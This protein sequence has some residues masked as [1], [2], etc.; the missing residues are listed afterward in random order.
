MRLSAVELSALL[1]GFRLEATPKT[2]T[3]AVPI[4]QLHSIRALRSE[5]I[6]GALEW[7]GQIRSRTK[8]AN[9]S[10]PLRESTG[11][12]ATSTQD[13]AQQSDHAPAF[14]VRSTLRSS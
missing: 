1:E 9:L 8:A 12:V 13:C 10:A 5:H 7:I 14:K 6:N 3:R 11:L 4:D 2:Y